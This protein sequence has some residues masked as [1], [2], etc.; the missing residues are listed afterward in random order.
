LKAIELKLEK[1][2]GAFVVPVVISDKITLEF[3][4]DSGQ[5]DQFQPMYSGALVRAGTVSIADL[6]DK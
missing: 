2:G 6:I 5:A 3:T 4:L 1:E